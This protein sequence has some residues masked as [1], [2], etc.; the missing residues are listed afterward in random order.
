VIRAFQ[1]E[2]A[3]EKIKARFFSWS[4]TSRLPVTRDQSE[5]DNNATGSRLLPRTGLQMGVEPND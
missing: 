2:A 4:I 1:S 3:N 5:V